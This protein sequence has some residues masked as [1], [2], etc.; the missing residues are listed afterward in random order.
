MSR[1]DSFTIL[2]Q[3]DQRSR[4]REQR[5]RQTSDA[6]HKLKWSATRSAAVDLAVPEFEILG[7]RR[8]LARGLRPEDA[9]AV[10]VHMGV[11]SAQGLAVFGKLQADAISLK[12]AVRQQ[13]VRNA[14]FWKRCGRNSSRD[15]R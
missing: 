14:R 13:D 8:G 1:H 15:I 2:T 9:S 7:T 3:P 10:L 12:R 5:H 6:C 4:D 11:T